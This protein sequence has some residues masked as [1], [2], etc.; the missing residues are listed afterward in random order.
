MYSDEIISE[1]WRNR[2]TYSEQHHH[3]LE[4]M[5]DD[6]KKRQENPHSTIV[7]RRIMNEN[8]LKS[9]VLAEQ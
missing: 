2:E 8:T 3:D 1:V 9:K 6:L 5:I 7:D 4:R